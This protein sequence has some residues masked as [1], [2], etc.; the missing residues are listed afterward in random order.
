MERSLRFLKCDLGELAKV[1]LERR[2][3]TPRLATPP[4]RNPVRCDRLALGWGKVVRRWATVLALLGCII[5]A[6]VLPWHAAS[7]HPGHWSSIALA[8]DLG[9][10]CHGGAAKAGDSALPPAPEA[11]ADTKIDC[12]I[13]K[14]LLGQQFAVIAS[15]VMEPPVRVARE[16]LLPAADHGSSSCFFQSP[17]NRGPPLSV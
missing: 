16:Q 17:R 15:S 4:L 8:A 14:G 9:A 13:C 3:A 7:R 12:P 10:I 1:A 6:M 5:H 2:R 11:P